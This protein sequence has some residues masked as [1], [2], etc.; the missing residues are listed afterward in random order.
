MWACSRGAVIEVSF[1]LGTSDW[2]LFFLR[3]QTSMYIF[4]FTWIWKQTQFPN[5]FCSLLEFRTT[6][7]VLKFSDFERYTPSSEPFKF[8]TNVGCLPLPHSSA[9]VRARVRSCGIRGRQSG[10]GVGF[11]RVLLFLL[12][13][14]PRTAP[15]SSSFII[16]GWCNRSKRG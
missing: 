11:L 13:N 4:P 5:C 6:D 3:D 10:T 9:R 1:F 15:R 12:P 8:N 14:I 2:N 7:K 16:R